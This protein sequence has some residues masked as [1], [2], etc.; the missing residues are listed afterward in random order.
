MVLDV[1][2]ETLQGPFTS[3]EMTRRLATDGAL[4]NIHLKDADA[5]RESLRYSWYW[6]PASDARCRHG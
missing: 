5:T 3:E 4:R 2:S 6:Q 1:K